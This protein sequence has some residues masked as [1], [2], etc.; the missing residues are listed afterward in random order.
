MAL[1]AVLFILGCAQQIDVEQEAETEKNTTANE[2]ISEIESEIDEID[3]LMA[4][5]D[6][7]EIDALD[8][9]IDSL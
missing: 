9:E 2:D 4:D 7:D 5:I 8:K 3:S 6:M 1:L